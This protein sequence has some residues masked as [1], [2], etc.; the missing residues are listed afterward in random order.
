M[1]KQRLGKRERIARKR[2]TSMRKQGHIV[3]RSQCSQCSKPETWK[4][5]PAKA[6]K[7]SF[8]TKL[9]CGQCRSDNKTCAG[10]Q[11]VGS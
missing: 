10:V 7:I 2:R 5:N 6:N 3:I 9:V 8:K 4:F 1:S 11:A